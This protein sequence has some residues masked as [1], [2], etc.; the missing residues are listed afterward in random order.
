MA[1][2]TKIGTDTQKAAW[3]VIDGKAKT[4]RDLATKSG[5]TMSKARYHMK[6]AAAAGIL[7]GAMGHGW[8]GAHADR[9]GRRLEFAANAQALAA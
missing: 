1:K 4:V 3:L 6:R 9:Y 7:G 8:N 2:G 5:W